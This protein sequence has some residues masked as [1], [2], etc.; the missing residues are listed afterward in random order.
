MRAMCATGAVE[1]RSQKIRGRD[2]TTSENVQYNQSSE[3]LCNVL[4]GIYE[5]T[6]RSALQANH[7]RDGKLLFKLFLPSQLLRLDYYMMHQKSMVRILDDATRNS[8]YALRTDYSEAK[9]IS[10]AALTSS[11]RP[12]EALVGDS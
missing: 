4:D 8:P 2:T 6:T 7:M 11:S 9:S 10:R 3:E 5:E 12:T 1:E